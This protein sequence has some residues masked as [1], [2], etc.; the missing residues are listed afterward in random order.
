MPRTRRSVTAEAIREIDRRLAQV[1]T[2]PERVRRMEALLEDI[3]RI[4]VDTVDGHNEHRHHVR[5][6]LDRI[7]T[8]VHELER[9]A[10]NGGE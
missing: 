2:M 8:R 6:Q 1:E 7:G 4:L 10:S 5:D 9:R 3:K